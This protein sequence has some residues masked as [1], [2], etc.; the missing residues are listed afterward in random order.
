MEMLVPERN[1]DHLLLDSGRGRK[2]E[3]FSGYTLDRPEPQ[4]DW[5]RSLPRSAWSEADAVFQ[6]GGEWR[7]RR[8]PPHGWV[9]RWGSLRLAIK[10]APYKHT[11]VFPEQ[12]SNWRWLIEAVRAAGP[13]PKVLNLF[14]YTGG[15]TLACALAGARVC[16][17][18]SSRPAVAWARENQRLSRLE[19][20]PVRWMVE[21]CLKFATREA[22]R[23]ARYQG[24]IMDPPAFGRGPGGKVFK[25]G[26]DVPRLLETCRGLMADGPCFFLL[27]SYNAG[28]GPKELAGLA[29]QLAPTARIESGELGLRQESGERVLPCGAFVRF[30]AGVA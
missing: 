8:E 13:E 9:F 15:A 27:N 7:V 26:R 21:D 11:G 29:S 19:S 18:D 10:L 3:I 12:Q 16:H 6:R 25:F 1:P 20:K 23:G 30:M 22:R 4:A 2:L 17:V 5:P 14:A 28:L 24:I